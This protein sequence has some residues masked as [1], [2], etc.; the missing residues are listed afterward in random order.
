MNKRKLNRPETVEI[1]NRTY[2]FVLELAELLCIESARVHKA[3]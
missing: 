2:S 3:R 1:K